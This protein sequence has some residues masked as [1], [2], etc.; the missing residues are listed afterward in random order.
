MKTPKSLWLYALI[1]A[2][3]AFIFTSCSTFNYKT[4][5]EQKDVDDPEPD[6]DITLNADFQEYTSY[7]FIGN[8]TENFGTYFNTF[9]NARENFDEAYED[10]ETRVLSTYSE[11]P[12]SIYAAPNVSQESKDKFNKSIEKA[13]KVIQYHKSSAFMDQAV[14]LIGK[15]YFYLGDYLKA[16]RKFSEF[17]SKLSKS[18]FIDEAFLFLAKTQLRLGDYE[19]AIARLE[20]LIKNSKDKSIVAGSYQAI[21][22]YYLNKKDYEASI[23]N[24]RSSIAYSSDNDFKAQMQF[25]IASVTAKQNPAKGAGEFNAVLKYNTS[26]ELEYLT[27][28]NHAKYL[29]LSSNFTGVPKL[30]DD[31]R[32]DYKEYPEYLSDIEYLAAKYYE[33]KKEYKTAVK[34]YKDVIINYPKTVASS[35][36]SFSIADYCENIAGDYLNAYRYYRYSNDENIKGH[37]AQVTGKKITI[38]KKYFDLRSTIAGSVI[39]T[40]YDSTFLRGLK[41]ELKPGEEK[42]IEEKIKGKGEDGGKPG[43]YRQVLKIFPDSLK[44]DSL[45]NEPVSEDSLKMLRQN[46]TKAKFELAELFIYNIDKPDSA[47]KYLDQAYNESDDYDFKSKVMYALADLYRNSGREEKYEEI[48][49]SIIKEYSLSPVA[50]ECRKLLNLP[51][52]TENIIT[53]EDSIF[54]SAESKFVSKE[55]RDALGGFLEIASNN[56]ASDYYAKSNYAAGWIYEN[57]FERPDS[58]Y[59]YYANV[60]KNAPASELSTV[61]ADKLTE[62]ENFLKPVNNDSL[63]A[64]S[65]K[66]APIEENKEPVENKIDDNTKIIDN[67]EGTPQK[68]ADIKKE[69]KN[70]GEDPTK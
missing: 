65:N 53:S 39:S 23:K 5:E 24:Y 49:R 48:L 14:L 3:T 47:E 30:I 54:S 12:D 60:V 31:L 50:D 8:R 26:F 17:V 64:D 36:A 7:M 9:F 58:A 16:E 22:E 38:F 57:I 28:Y 63:T 35:D 70:E 27:R 10:Y 42:K 20:G 37:N 44:N 46:V 52:V 45:K 67:G 66:I 59:I 68:D 15:C 4:Y 19:Q 18:P 69:D 56:P 6:Y 33:Q 61:V 55:Y 1:P 43:S 13:S 34:K 25:L 2:L 32:I 41:Q 29:I 51:A 21:G 11:R 62:Y 40:D